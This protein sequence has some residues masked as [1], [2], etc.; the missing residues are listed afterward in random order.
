MLVAIA[1]Y[2]MVVGAASARSPRTAGTP[3]DRAAVHAYLLDMYAYAQAVAA[4]APA[5]VGAY[6]STASRIA[7]EC[8]SVLAGAPHESGIEL[9][10][11]IVQRTAR[12]RG[13]EKRQS[14]QLS[15]LKEE[16]AMELDSVGQEARRPAVTTFLA[17]LKALPQGGPALSQVVHAQTIGLEEEQ[18]VESADA[19]ADMKA[20]AASGY[21]TL[22]AASRAVALKTEAE[23]VEFFRD[24]ST[25]SARRALSAS[26]SLAATETPVD[27]ALARKTAQLEL[28]VAKAISGHLDGAHKRVEAALGLTAREKREKSLEQTSHETKSSAELGTGRTAAGTSYT[29]WLERT[30]GGSAGMCKSSVEVRRGSGAGLGVLELLGIGSNVCLAPRQDRSEKPRVSCSEGLLAITTEVPPATRTVDLRLSNGTHVVS[31]PLLVPRRLGG[32]AAFYYQAVRGPSPVLVSLTERDVHGRTLG[33]RKLQ[34]IVGCS[35]HPLD[36]CTVAS[37]RSSAGVRP[38]AR[39]SRSSANATGCSVVSTPS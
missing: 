29:V 26:E 31:R 14:T 38:K 2:A 24:L 34:R 13:E 37:A 6:E 18:K 10:S 7:G 11:P 5:M 4:V 1:V 19:C 17:S 30:K 15:D 39:A 21:R 35:V 27:K 32:P 22:S 33:V 28:R 9:G 20:W 23:L 25:L 12:Q 3:A 8:P 36:T 16:L